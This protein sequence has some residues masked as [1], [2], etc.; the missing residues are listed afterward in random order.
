MLLAG[1][2]VAAAVWL[3]LPRLYAE[4]PLDTGV[5]P[6]SIPGMGF[7]VEGGP[8][9]F[10]PGMGLALGE[11]NRG[12]AV[13]LTEALLD[14]DA[15]PLVRLDLAGVHPDL[16]VTLA[17]RPM[18]PGAA[19]HEL[20]LHRGA[21]EVT[22]HQLAG[23]PGWQGRILELAVEVRGR[24]AFAPI[25]LRSLALY[26]ATRSDLARLLWQDWRVMQPWRQGSANHYRGALEHTPLMPVP[27]VTAWL[28]LALVLFRVGLHR[29]RLP[30]Q[31]WLPAVMGMVLVA[32]LAV[33]AVWQLRLTEQVAATRERFGGLD[34]A[35]RRSRE[36]DAFLQRHAHQVLEQLQPHRGQRVFILR[37]SVQHEYN[38]LRL[39]YHLLPLNVYNFGQTLPLPAHGRPGDHVIVL[40]QPPGVAF[41][42]HT[43]VLDDGHRRW[44]A[45][46]VL[47]LPRLDLFRLEQ[48][49]EPLP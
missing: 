13:F 39:Q 44:R 23:Q 17:W 4:V 45:S 22:W 16:G 10:T 15:Y 40:D 47:E 2:L 29:R 41:D 9:S 24:H 43:G 7:R 14:V 21:A 3:W 35:E 38:R 1:L 20:A 27:V 26:P 5:S 19:W 12:R 49:L 33:D 34:Q 31:A 11:L 46:P 28:L 30:V 8:A 42:P 6:E 18:Q 25:E 32:W 48:P 36:E 37:E